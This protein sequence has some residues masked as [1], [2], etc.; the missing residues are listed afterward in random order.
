VLD[1]CEPSLVHILPTLARLGINKVEHL[2]AVAK[3]TPATRD[4]EI[5]EDALRMGITVMEWAIFVDKIFT[6]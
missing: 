4:R 5:R 1:S 2:R 6:M 3:L